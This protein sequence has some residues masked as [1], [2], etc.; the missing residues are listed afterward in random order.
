MEFH[1][2]LEV[3]N[4]FTEKKF[5]EVVYLMIQIGEDNSEAI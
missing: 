2:F 5:Q 3:L 1:N 4:F